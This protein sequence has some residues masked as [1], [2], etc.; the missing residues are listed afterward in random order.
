[1]R[2]PVVSRIRNFSALGTTLALLH[3]HYITG[4]I[5]Y[6]RWIN[7]RPSRR[8]TPRSG[9]VHARCSQDENDDVPERAVAHAE[10]VRTWADPDRLDPE[11]TSRVPGR[12]QQEGPLAAER[13][14]A[15]RP[16]SPQAGHGS[17]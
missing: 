6:Q 8:F 4:R 7:L 2:S 10:R 9:E 3:R 12:A 14:P 17:P 16:D 11:A 13:E 1:M 15:G 5:L